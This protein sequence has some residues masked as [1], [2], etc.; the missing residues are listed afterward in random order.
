MQ[1]KSV[2]DVGA[3]CRGISVAVLLMAAS[4]AEGGSINDNVSEGWPSKATMP[5]GL[6]AMASAVWGGSLYVAGGYSSSG[7]T[8]A[9][10]RYDGGTN[11][12]I[13]PSLPA[14]HKAVSAGMFVLGSSL[15][16]VGG[17]I[18]GMASS[19]VYRYDG[20]A[21]SAGPSLPDGRRDFAVAVCN[22]YAYVIGG[23]DSSGGMV[24]TVYRFDG[25][26]WTTS[27]S[28]PMA[29]YCLFAATVNNT[30]YV[31]GGLTSGGVQSTAVL[32]FD[33]TKWTSVSTMPRWQYHPAV[34]VESNRIVVIGGKNT[35]YS[36]ITNIVSF[37][38]AGWSERKSLPWPLSDAAAGVV[39]DRLYVA[40]GGEGYSPSASTLFY[41]TASTG[42]TPTSCAKTGGTQVTIIGSGLGNGT[43]ITNVTLC[44]VAVQSINSQ[45]ATQVVV[46]AGASPVAGSGDVRVFSTSCGE[47]VKSNYFSY[48]YYGAIAG[49][50][51][52]DWGYIA[53]GA[54]PD[55]TLGTDFG[56][57]D[58]GRVATNEWYLSED[59]AL[60]P[61][62]FGAAQITGPGAAA[63]SIVGVPT[64]IESYG[65]T[66][67][68]IRF[69]PTTRGLYTA[70][71]SLPN[72]GEPSPFV[73]NLSGWGILDAEIN[74]ESVFGVQTGGFGFSIVGEANKKVVVEA[75]T[76]L[77]VPVWSPVGTNVLLNGESVFID[78]QWMNYP[79][80]FYRLRAP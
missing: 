36:S 20:S 22:G 70:T 37:D 60:L 72:D 67:L 47:T 39:N 5:K 48:Y 51:T 68:T 19:A 21:W 69:A 31:M 71:V 58:A 49:L 44:G 12:T 80:R 77:I 78:A 79:G 65:Y 74:R 26:S 6:C 14:S 33:S 9:V 3:L 28:L 25:S 62:T 63:Y 38:G 42:V 29:H 73:I 2:V 8:N 76:N 57:V 32:R 11:W 27:V 18:D 50:Y 4:G 34:C 23:C 24:N 1:G 10:F 75:C 64:S 41:Q 61:L 56:G 30:L 45:N 13:C 46:T 53:S 59:S 16:F 40:G 66:N 17:A 35:A 7:A 52:T 55:A 43:D 15:Y 54:A